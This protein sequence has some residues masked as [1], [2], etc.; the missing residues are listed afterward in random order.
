MR[1]KMVCILIILVILLFSFV[2]AYDARS[3]ENL[4][5]AIAI[6]IDK[7]EE[8]E[9]RL[10]VQF[11]NPGVLQEG[12]TNNEPTSNITVECASVNSGLDIINSVMS[13]QVNLSQCKVVV[14]SEAIAVE[15]VYQY[16]NNLVNIVEIR[17]N[18]NIIISRCSAKDFLKNSKPMTETML[19]KYYEAIVNGSEYTGVTDDVELERFYSSCND[20]AA[21]SYAILAGI[22]TGAVGADSIFA[23]ME[24]NDNVNADLKYKADEM[25]VVDGVNMQ[26]VGLAVFRGDKLVGELNGLETIAHL[27]VSN[28][29]K[30]CVLNIPSPFVENATI[31]IR[32]RQVKPT[33]NTVEYDRGT[34]TIYSDIFLDGEIIEATGF[35]DF[36]SS[37]NL[38]KV[39]DASDKY[40][41][42]LLLD[43]LYKTS[44]EFNSDIVGFGRLLLPRYRTVQEWEK[45][46]WLSKYEN[47]VF[48]VNVKCNINEGELF[49]KS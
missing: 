45:I 22:N 34:A 3:I 29:I 38:Q 48:S 5:Y 30:N 9:L 35:Y 16:I 41:K 15:G 44:K 24:S 46:N 43:Y 17:P 12:G 11:V 23:Q 10:S 19:S 42:K 13:K 32:I 49:S 28:K 6:G 21:E 7:G 8:K 25:P 26:S 37:E 14:F 39:T 47:S 20:T 27:I 18:C 31:A 40:I 1:R 4:S 2:G 36:S 33:K